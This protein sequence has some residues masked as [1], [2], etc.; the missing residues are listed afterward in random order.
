V[1]IDSDAFVSAASQDA[2]CTYLQGSGVPATRS[3]L[4]SGY[5]HDAFLVDAGAL[6]GPLLRT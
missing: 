2:L 1:R 6:L 3:T 4:D 5:G